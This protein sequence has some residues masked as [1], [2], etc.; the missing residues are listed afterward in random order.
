M[1]PKLAN[2]NCITAHHLTDAV[3]K[4]TQDKTSIDISWVA[5]TPC[6]RK[7]AHQ[8]QRQFPQIQR[9]HYWVTCFTGSEESELDL[10]HHLFVF[11]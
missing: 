9:L 6:R 8:S 3:F 4:K 5:Q 2:T 11:L 1:L 10:R 7:T